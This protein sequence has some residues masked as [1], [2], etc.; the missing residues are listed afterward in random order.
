M[1][2]LLF[3]VLTLAIGFGA[4]G[5]VNHQLSKNSR[6]RTSTG[7]TGAQAAQQMLRYYGIGN[8]AVK[9]GGQGQDFFDPKTNSITLSPSSYGVSSITAIATACHEVG[10]ACQ[11]AQDYAPMKLRTAMVPAVNLCSNAWIIILMVGIFL[12]LA[13][14]Q[15]IAVI[16]YAAV[17]LF[18]L[19][20]LPVELNASKRAIGYMETVGMPAEEV[21]SSS[22][23]LRACAYTY[24]AAALTSLLQLIYL[25]GVARD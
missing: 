5:F 19:V 1:S 24:L 14:L 25:L 2:Y 20:T 11:Y 6:I 8:V 12:N 21:K 4:S 9:P 23:V 17:V 13:G 18:A 16:L 22:A 3:I 10:H 15:M 7:L